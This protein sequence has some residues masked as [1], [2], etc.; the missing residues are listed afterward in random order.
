MVAMKKV[1]N[2]AFGCLIS[3]F[4]L[5]AAL[6]VRAQGRADSSADVLADRSVS[7]S[8]SR[9]YDPSVYVASTPSG[10]ATTSRRSTTRI[11][12]H[13]RKTQGTNAATVTPTRTLK[14]SMPVLPGAVYAPE[15]SPGSASGLPTRSPYSHS[16]IVAFDSPAANP[17]THIY[18]SPGLI[19]QR[20]GLQGGLHAPHRP[21][22]RGGAGNPGNYGTP[23]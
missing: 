13:Q 23:R 9:T 19:K 22:A 12:S 21:Y 4:A 10:G 1:N 14:P 18:H 16:S 2:V 20:K 6:S 5:S 11:E 7:P 15:G 3:W 17:S 8:V